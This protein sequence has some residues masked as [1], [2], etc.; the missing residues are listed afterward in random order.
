[1]VAAL[2]GAAPAFVALVDREGIAW[3]LVR[4]FDVSALVWIGCW[5][6]IGSMLQDRSRARLSRMDAV[7]LVGA[8]AAT[9]APIAWLSWIA[10]TGACIFAAASSPRAS[11]LRRGAIVMLCVAL[12]MFWSGV[13]LALAG[14]IV[15]PAETALAG[16]LVG[17]EWSGNVLAAR[18]ATGLVLVVAA[19]SAVPAVALSI[20]CWVLFMTASRKETATPGD[21]LVLAAACAAP[22]LLNAL[23][24]GLVARHESASDLLHG[25]VAGQAFGWLVTALI[26]A[27]CWLGSAREQR[28]HVRAAHR[29]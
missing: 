2:N 16:L 10:L 12:A 21:W 23:R 9:L 18:D 5:L 27:I 20:L 8:A 19:C 24:V 1:M 13:V 17:V 3:S 7:V 29:C 22:I 14:D 28:A 26:V 4:G 15:L 25:P 11:G 6:G